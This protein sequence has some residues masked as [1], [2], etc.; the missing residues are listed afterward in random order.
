MMTV[1]NGFVV[2]T[3]VR[4]D[5][6]TTRR[7][8]IRQSAVTA[9]TSDSQYSYVNVFTNGEESFLIPGSLEDVL[10]ALAQ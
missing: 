6:A 1:K 8:A 2:F 9:V 4:P 3:V 7:I 10:E 5:Q